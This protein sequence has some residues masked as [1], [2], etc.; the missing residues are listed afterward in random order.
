MCY[1]GPW[2]DPTAALNRY[3]S[4]RDDLYAGRTPRSQLEGITVREVC[5]H[6]LTSKQQ[7]RDSREINDRTF[8]DYY[9]ACERMLGGINGSRIVADL[10]PHDFEHLRGKLSKTLGTVALGNAIQHVR[11]VFKYA[12]DQGLVERPVRYGQTFRKP[13]VK[14]VRQD[15]A[16]RTQERGYRMFEAA[17]IK[18]ILQHTDKQLKAMT[19][20]GINC[21]FGQTEIS[22]MPKSV[23]DL[24][25][26]WVA[27]ITPPLL[28]RVTADD[29]EPAVDRTAAGP[30]IGLRVEYAPSQLADITS[31][32]QNDQS[33]DRVNQVVRLTCR[34]SGVESIQCGLGGKRETPQIDY[35]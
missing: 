31:W 14:S 10:T 7:L 15:R 30:L 5:N 27:E 13:N 24:K 3:L 17:A 22:R 21:V 25:T 34:V 9:S 1:F 6:Y 33:N 20:F 2:D 26:G 16:R 12:F 29:G 4:Q 35:L 11:M 8:N 32:F 23:L 28:L 19:L 18:K